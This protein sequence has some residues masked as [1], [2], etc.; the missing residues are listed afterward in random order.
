M[1][2]PVVINLSTGRNNGSL[3]NGIIITLTLGLDGGDDVVRSPVEVIVLGRLDQGALEVLQRR[4]YGIDFQDTV[5]Y[6]NQ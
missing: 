5:V 1:S 6:G 4:G 2:D 3:R